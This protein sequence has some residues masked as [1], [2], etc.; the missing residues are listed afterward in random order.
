MDSPARLG[1][2][3]Q[4]GAVEHRHV[5]MQPNREAHERLDQAYELGGRPSFS[6]EDERHVH[7]QQ[8]KVQ[9]VSERLEELYADVGGLR[10]S[11]EEPERLQARDERGEAEDREVYGEVDLD[12]DEELLQG[13]IGFE[14]VEDQRD[15]DQRDEDEC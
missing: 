10:C 11:V 5:V 8:Q 3:A 15:E 13:E 4:H 1:R 9:D 2:L 6:G 7:E 14:S 12:E